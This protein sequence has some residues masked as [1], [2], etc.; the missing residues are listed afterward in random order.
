[1]RT[2]RKGG[3]TMKHAVGN[4]LIYILSLTAAIIFGFV[5]I[6]VFEI[7]IVAIA[8]L[9]AFL[10]VYAFFI[11]FGWKSMRK[12]N[13]YEQ[14]LVHFGLN[15]GDERKILFYSL[16]TLSPMWLCIFLVS[17]IPL[18]TNGVWIITI[19]PCMFLSCVPAATVLEEFYGLTHKKLP[20]V[21]LFLLFAVICCLLGVVVSDLIFG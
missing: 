21:L 9:L 18:F 12:L 11:A 10:A 8:V 20:F 5:Y 4:I 19:F 15:K 3:C 6:N 7:S 16:S 2:S 14:K 1:M 13:A 17:C